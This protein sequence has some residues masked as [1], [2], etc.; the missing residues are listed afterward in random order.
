MRTMRQFPFL[1]RRVTI[2][3]ALLIAVQLSPVAADNQQRK[4]KES[5]AKRLIAL[6]RTAEKQG[7]LLEAR[8]QYLASEHVLFHT[9]AEEGLERI[10]VAAREQVKTMMAD[11]AQAYTTENFAKA[12]QLLESAA[13]L[14]PGHLG[15]RLQPGADAIPAGQPRAGPELARSMC[16]RAARQGAA[17]AVG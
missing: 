15:D 12:A 4:A 14:H 17:P 7:R 5:E 11:A 3:C 10:A 6:G 8:R 9:D 16:W 1:P 13:A 2:L